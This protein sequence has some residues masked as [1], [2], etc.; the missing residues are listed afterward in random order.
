MRKINLLLIEDSEPDA[1]LILR[2]MER[3]GYAVTHKRVETADEIQA[4]LK[5]QKWDLVISDFQLPQ[6]YAP[7]VLRLV[8]THG[9]DVPFIV[10]S[11]AIGEETAA[12]MV[13][14]GANDYVMKDNL[15]RLGAAVERELSLAKDKRRLKKPA[16]SASSDAAE[17]SSAAIP[18]TASLMLDALPAQVAL[19]DRAGLII[20]VNQ[21][22]R[23]Y[24]EAAGLRH[25]DHGVGITFHQVLRHELG[26]APA[27]ETTLHQDIMQMLKGEGRPIDVGFESPAKPER[28]NC[29]LSVR[30]VTQFKRY[31]GIVMH[32]VLN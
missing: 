22:W 23:T 1:A 12:T 14:I 6:L 2:A 19:L 11:G 18:T 29:R 20:A 25:A 26:M 27:N 31:A 5:E 9:D 24:V 15:S 32:T 28:V 7:V 8:R 30:P 16:A 10:V 4:C 13:R 21:P 17:D 3:A